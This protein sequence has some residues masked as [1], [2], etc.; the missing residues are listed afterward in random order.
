MCQDPALNLKRRLRHSKKESKIYMDIMLD[1][2]A[3]RNAT[4]DSRKQE[5]AQRIFD[6]VPEVL[7]RFKIPDFDREEFVADLREWINGT[8]WRK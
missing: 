4:S 2:P 8:G 5:V 3:M 7:G 6:E 1:L